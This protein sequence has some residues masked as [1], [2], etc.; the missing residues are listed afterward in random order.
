M[1]A[2]ITDR[3]TNH[4]CAIMDLN[5]IPHYAILDPELTLGLPPRTTATTGMDA[6][7]HAVE[8]YLCWTYNTRESIRDAEEA[9]Q[10]IFVAKCI[11]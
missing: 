1:A 11:P 5:L 8:A 4:K 7:T 10:S 2:V 6:L 9:V 3:E